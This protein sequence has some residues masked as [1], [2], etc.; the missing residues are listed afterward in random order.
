[1]PLWRIRF[2]VTVKRYFQNQ[3]SGRV[4]YLGLD[5]GTKG[6]MTDWLEL[7]LNYSYIH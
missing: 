1:M 5:I 2:I 4:D 6:K 7:G 3:N